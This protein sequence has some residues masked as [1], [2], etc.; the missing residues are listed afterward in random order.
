MDTISEPPAGQLELAGGDGYQLGPGHGGGDR[1]VPLAATTRRPAV[2]MLS[3]GGTT[4][5]VGHGWLGCMRRTSSI[6]KCTVFLLIQGLKAAKCHYLF[7]GSCGLNVGWRSAPASP[8][9]SLEPPSKH[10][11]Q[12][13]KQSAAPIMTP[14][15][16]YRV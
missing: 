7:L 9:P 14:H 8:K 4:R 10:C 2:G 3:N 11:S 16:A 13:M 5:L 12:S 6:A 15:E 1:F